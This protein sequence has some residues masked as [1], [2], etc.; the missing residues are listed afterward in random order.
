MLHDLSFAQPESTKT[1]SLSL[2]RNLSLSEKPSTVDLD[3]VLKKSAHSRKL[4]FPS[5]MNFN[6]INEPIE[7]LTEKITNMSTPVDPKGKVIDDD[8]L[9]VLQTKETTNFVDKR[10]KLWNLAKEVK[11]SEDAL[12]D[13]D[14]FIKDE[15]DELRNDIHQI[16][17]LE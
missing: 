6:R 10:R 7:G 1:A 11:R 15:G 14:M 13:L 12:L 2:H 17:S 16:Y 5:I 8:E 9:G 3:P 4:N